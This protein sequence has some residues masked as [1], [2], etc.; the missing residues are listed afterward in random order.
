MPEISGFPYFE[1]QF[2]KHGELEIPDQVG[3]LLNHIRTD[4]ESDLVVLAHGWNNDTE[5]ARRLYTGLLAELR[6]AL[7][8]RRTPGVPDLVI[9][10]VFWPSKKFVDREVVPSPAAG[11]DS[12]L[13][14]ADI[15]EQ[16]DHL[17]TAIGDPS[18]VE[19]LETAKALVPKLEDSPK[20]QAAFADLVRS[21]L[22]TDAAEIGEEDASQTFFEID[23]KDLME[24]LAKPVD[25]DVD[26]TTGLAS[27]T[28]RTEIDAMGGA[29]G[30]GDFF[31]GM[32]SAAR[33]LL[34]YSTY[35]LMKERSGT[36]GEGL[37]AV[38][39]MIREVRPQQKVHL[40][41]HSFGARLVTAATGGKDTGSALTVQSMVLLQA[42]FSHNG[43]A[44]NFD[45]NG[46]NGSFRRV[47]EDNLVQGPLLISHTVHD[48]AVGVAYPLASLISGTDSAGLGDANDPYGGLGRNGA[49][50]TPEAI[51]GTLLPVQDKY[52]FKKGKVYNLRADSVIGDHGRIVHPE[53]AHAM[54]SAIATAR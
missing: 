3:A 52:E 32:K 50:H 18:A 23:G 34:N 12:L 4:P 47:V 11:H 17:E 48:T 5:D 8:A 45:G 20:A 24:R 9:L 30:L 44:V 10:A 15:L 29:A 27:G 19:R 40:V 51:A 14:N 39:R 1:V 35:Y 28:A 13:S 53:V 38:I 46:K 54:V 33:N 43:F 36:V 16:I 42:A 22:P 6:T 26:M 31:T 37:N 21:M 2:D 49:Q 7:T 25:H 41:G